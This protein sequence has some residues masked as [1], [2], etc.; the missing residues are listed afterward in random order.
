MSSPRVLVFAGSLRIDSF[1][2]KL[3]AVA[4]ERVE[5]NGGEATL[6]DL[7]DYRIP[8][9]DGDMEIG[10]GVP[11]RAQ[12][13]R[14]LFVDHDAYFIASPEYNGSIPG[15]LKNYLD[16]ISRPDGDVPGLVAFQN[17]VAGIVS[18]SPGALGGLRGLR[19]LRE[20]LGNLGSLVIPEQHAIGGAMKAF[21]TDGS[22]NNERDAKGV[23]KVAKRLVEV[24][25][26][27][28]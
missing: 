25:G 14:N 13:L 11:E 15:T 20:V 19:H 9:Y 21:N 10:G 4:A 18:A 2:K 23:E 27:L 26:R 12:T 8:P 17:K 3:A 22:L 16:W 28:I 6:I 7:R 5:A 24:T 1:N